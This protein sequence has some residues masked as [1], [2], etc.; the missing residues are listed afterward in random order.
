MWRSYPVT[1]LL[2]ALAVLDMVTKRAKMVAK[3]AKRANLKCWF[4]WLGLVVL[5]WFLSCSDLGVKR[6]FSGQAFRLIM[7]TVEQLPQ[8]PADTE[9][10]K[11]I[12]FWWAFPT[13]RS[14]FS[15]EFRFTQTASR[16]KSVFGCCFSEDQGKFNGEVWF[17]ARCR[18]PMR[19]AVMK[20]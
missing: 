7:G 15:V 17:T 16:E 6:A 8:L 3:R 14:Q 10:S 9:I 13:R 11:R 19:I 1:P 20:E 2:W 18:A 5:F 4:I 12:N